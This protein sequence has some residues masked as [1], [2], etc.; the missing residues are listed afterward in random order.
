[1]KIDQTPAPHGFI[2]WENE[3]FKCV[4]CGLVCT[5]TTFPTPSQN[6]CPASAGRWMSPR[7]IAYV[8]WGIA[9]LSFLSML[10]TI[11]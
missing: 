11:Q 6:V 1:M 5:I 9:T 3:A 8:I 2:W 10:T 4:K 7:T